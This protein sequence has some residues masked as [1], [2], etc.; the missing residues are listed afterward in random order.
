MSRTP[1]FPLYDRML[2]G[3]LALLLLRWREDGLSHR[4]I[5]GRLAADYDVHVSWKTVGR[6]L[7]DLEG[8]GAA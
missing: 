7:A 4:A 3:R 2:G 1:T 5:A 8:P 6:W